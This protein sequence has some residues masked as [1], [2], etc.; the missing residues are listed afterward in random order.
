MRLLTSIVLALAIAL[1]A[2]AAS[3]NSLA[4][5]VTGTAGDAPVV[6]G[7]TVDFGPGGG[8][9]T[10]SITL[11]NTQAISGVGVSAA[12]DPSAT[13]SGSQ[14][15]QLF[16]FI[17]PS[18]FFS[19]GSLGAGPVNA[20]PGG[21]SSWNFGTVGTPLP[22]GSYAMGTLTV[23]A[24]ASTS[25]TVGVLTQND[26]YT[27]DSFQSIALAPGV[28]QINVVPEPGTALLMG[29]GIIGLAVAGRRE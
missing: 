3:A 27:D 5:A 25:V 1:T 2:A 11:T 29:L 15:A 26:D 13:A 18:T 8:S 10:Y 20:S 19:M 12:F 4:L 22:A 28:A 16:L 7:N 17:P 21:L 23:N 9:V 24:T 6:S 14:V